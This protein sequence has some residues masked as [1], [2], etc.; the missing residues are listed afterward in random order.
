M[1]QWAAAFRRAAALPPLLRSPRP[2]AGSRLASSGTVL[3][4]G[5]AGI[6]GG[7]VRLPRGRYTY[8]AVRELLHDRYP[9]RDSP[10]EPWRYPLLQSDAFTWRAADGTT[11]GLV[12]RTWDAAGPDPAVTETWYTTPPPQPT[13]SPG[14]SGGWSPDP[15]VLAGQLAEWEPAHP[16]PIY[17]LETA[18]MRYRTILPTTAQHAAALT[19]LCTTPG[20]HYDGPVTDQTG[21]P[22]I[23][24]S[25]DDDYSTGPTASP[26]PFHHATVVLDPTTWR[27]QAF[28]IVRPSTSGWPDDRGVVL[29]DAGCRAVVG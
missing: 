5:G 3:Q 11:T 12:R 27:V 1:C 2:A 7:P 15:A 25:A 24:L 28:R 21:R 19:V 22:G 6:G 29:L 9:W 26:G 14:T 13:P 4:G 17:M 18:A 8:L 16:R 10:A 23:G 20:V